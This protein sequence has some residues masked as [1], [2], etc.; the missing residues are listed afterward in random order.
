MALVEYEGE[1]YSLI[2]VP[3]ET[4]G[5]VV[6]E[7][8]YL[9]GEL[10]LEAL[11]DDLSRAGKFVRV[12][13]NGVAGNTELQI[14]VQEIGY[15][16]TKLCNKAA[17]TVFKFSRASHSVVL[18]LQ[19]TYEYLLDGLEEM[20]VDT[21][22][23][24]SKLAGDMVK[25]AKELGE[26]FEK[27]EEKIEDVLKKTQTQKGNEEKEKREDEKNKK[28][29]DDAI[30][31]QREAIEHEKRA[32][33]AYRKAQQEEIENAGAATGFALLSVIIVPAA[34][35][36]VAKA[37]MTGMK[38]REAKREKI[39]Q[40]EAMKKYSDQRQEALKEIAK[41]AKK[42][43]SYDAS[44]Q[45]TAGGPDAAIDAL[46][47][48]VTALKQL[49]VTMMRAEEFWKKMEDHCKMISDTK[50]DQ[51]LEIALKDG[52]EKVWANQTF[53]KNALQ[54]FAQWVA[55]QGVCAEYSKKVKVIQEQLYKSIQENPTIEE[56]RA[57]IKA[58]A[59]DLLKDIEKAH[60]D[61]ELDRA[62]K[63]KQ[64]S[65]CHQGDTGE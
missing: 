2:K 5:V 42:I 62:R 23:A 33:E 53:K 14:I 8:E 49:T 36:T 17:I 41:F 19:S 44:A 38:A 10:G 25:A 59:A 47:E 46:H 35:Y 24:V 45:M 58:I 20:A 29:K 31:T 34:P 60:K 51:K 54:F 22:G 64:I 4:S 55:L 30:K 61:I 3:P 43:V 1:Q 11:V 39:K 6:A 65:E 50:I 56:S 57:C 27:E 12:A 16:I 52:K 9:F 15:D 40:L 18:D 26:A 37:V 28:M 48:A 7:K 32:E 13:Y 63:D 21:L